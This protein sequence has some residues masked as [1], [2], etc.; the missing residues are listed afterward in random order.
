MGT[1]NRQRTA[2]QS[3]VD[4]GAAPASA[5][6]RFGPNYTDSTM[7]NDPML[8]GVRNMWGQQAAQAQRTGQ[9]AYDQWQGQQGRNQAF[10]AMGRQAVQGFSP[11]QAMRGLFGAPRVNLTGSAPVDQDMGAVQPNPFEWWRR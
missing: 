10:S 4:S 8:T 3:V 7:G 2:A 6:G 9:A 5:V 1:P 11:Q